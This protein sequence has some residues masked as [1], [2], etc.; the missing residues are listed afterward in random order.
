[1]LHA[2]NCQH[3]CHTIKPNDIKTSLGELV[4]ISVHIKLF[5]PHLCISYK[6]D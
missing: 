5:K 3:K 4:L 2:H 1:M 6:T